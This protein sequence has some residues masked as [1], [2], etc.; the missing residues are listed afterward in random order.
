M[1]MHMLEWPFCRR[2]DDNAYLFFSKMWLHPV[3]A[4]NRRHHPTFTF[5]FLALTQTHC[6]S[7]GSTT[8]RSYNK[9]I[10]LFHFSGG[11]MMSHII[12]HI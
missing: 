12:Y 2:H 9:H 11:P 7:V 4:V 3:R 6:Y 10:G 8:T 5:V 1:H